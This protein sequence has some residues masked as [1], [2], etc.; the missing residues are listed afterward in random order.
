[1]KPG[2]HYQAHIARAVR[3][4][5]CIG[6]GAIAITLMIVAIAFSL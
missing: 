5:I 6:L 3:Q 2:P 1:M 4:L